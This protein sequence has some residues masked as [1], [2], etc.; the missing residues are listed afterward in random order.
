VD[1]TGKQL[2]IVPIE[3]ALTIASERGLDLVE[4]AP[5]A[6]PPVCRIMDYGKYKYDLS[7]KEKASRK[8][9]HTVQVKEIRFRPK[10][11]EHDLMFKIKHARK[12]LEEGNRVKVTVLFRG[13]EMAHR[14]FG[15]RLLQR[16]KEEL[17]DVAKVEREP[18]MEGRLMVMHLAKK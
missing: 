8:R 11:D 16:V 4:V 12:F 2:G 1:E 7:K 17:E 10:I 9:Q 5:E 15:T 3:E 18:Q 14:E 6:Q 13:R